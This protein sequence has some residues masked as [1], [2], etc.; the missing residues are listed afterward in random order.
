V[1]YRTVYWN[2]D[3]VRMIDQTLLPDEFREID[4]RDLETLWEAIRV[5]RVRGAPAIGVAAALGVAMAARKS[6]AADTEE[7]LAEVDRAAEYLA[8]ARPTAVNLFWA[9]DR[10]RT[11]AHGLDTLEPREVSDRLLREAEN[12]IEEDHA[13]CMAIGRNGAALLK[14]GDT[15]LTHC[16][17]GALATAGFGTALG[18]VYA[19]WEAGK[20]VKV[21]ADE[22]RPLLQGARITSW[23]L[24]HAGVDVTLICDNMAAVV[25]RDRGVDAVI[26][27]ADR[28]AANGDFANKIGTYGLAVL[29][30]A[31]E[32]PF[33][34]AAPLSTIDRAAPT[35]AQIPIEERPAAE[36][37]EGFGRRT[38]PAEVPVYNP[39]FDVTPASYLAGIITEHG[40]LSPPFTDSIAKAFATAEG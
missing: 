30:R 21:F 12:M 4:C 18:V 7:L 5:L 10:M 37:I 29:A 40:V 26:V 17:A 9:L 2:D 16:N 13:V 3:C 23:E 27:G 24:L 20:R 1:K 31:H 38:A 11:V 36:I 32:V 8:T 22:T 34:T 35:G 39:A 14:D 15:V 33:Y 28:I 19:A 6:P 25:M